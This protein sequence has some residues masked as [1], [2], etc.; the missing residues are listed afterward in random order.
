M[1]QQMRVL[2]VDDSPFKFGDSKAL[3]IGALVR[4][5]NY[6]E[7]VMRSEVTVDGSDST[8]AVIA[9]ISRSRYR[10]QIR[11]VMFDGIALAGFNVLDLAKVHETLGIPVIAV[12]RDEPD[13]GKM[14]A[15]LVKHF[16]DWKERYSLM[17]R[18]ELKT[19]RTEHNPLFASGIGLPWH[20]LEELVV[21][22]TVR[23][24][25]PEPIRMAHLIATAM[26]KGESHGRS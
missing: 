17:T 22:S 25:V 2:G 21:K 7:G 18:L 1:K 26:A 14:R 8:D 12:T 11:A 3:V 23:G 10:E 9:M 19:I 20:D 24:V 13:L 16:D 4:V 5:P 15:A 6:L